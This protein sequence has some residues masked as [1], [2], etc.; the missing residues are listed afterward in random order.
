MNL[1]L[2]LCPL[3]PVFSVCVISCS[4]KK[5]SKNPNAM[6]GSASTMGYDVDTLPPPYA[7]PSSKNFSKVVG[8]KEGET[9]VA[10][11][12]FVVTKFADG[13][14]HPRWIYVAENG[15][16]AGRDQPIR[17]YQVTNSATTKSCRAKVCIVFSS[18]CFKTTF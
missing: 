17:Q 18:H 13:L 11:P 1:K 6:G 5:I 8:W 3:L 4:S 9:P 2:L 14:D 12:G 7:T 10:P 16:N 15:D